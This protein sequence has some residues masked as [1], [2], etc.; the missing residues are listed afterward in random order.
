MSKEREL[1]KR[2][3]D[4][5]RELKETH[6]NL[7]WDIQ[8]M[9]DHQLEQEQ[10]PAAWITEWVQRYRCDST[11]VMDRAVSFTKC[12]APAVPNPNYIPLY[13]SPPKLQPLSDEWL[14][15][16]I[17]FIHRDVSFTD[18]VR[19]VEKAHGIGE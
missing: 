15:D 12:S 16:N 3:R 14:K 19:G 6:Y 2:V 13:T 7:Y 9:L 17:G 1:L 10:T 8:S 4:A 18:L 11:P 5:L